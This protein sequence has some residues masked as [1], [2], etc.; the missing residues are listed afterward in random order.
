VKKAT[1]RKGKE[2]DVHLI[3]ETHEGPR[4][5]DSAYTTPNAGPY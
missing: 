5:V 3:D 4:G 1:S 2:A